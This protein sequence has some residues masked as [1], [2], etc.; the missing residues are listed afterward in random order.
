MDAFPPIFRVARP[1]IGL[2]KRML[3]ANLPTGHDPDQRIAGMRRRDGGEPIKPFR[4][5]GG[6]AQRSDQYWL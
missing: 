4:R 6:K 1:F 2:D 5:K 3:A